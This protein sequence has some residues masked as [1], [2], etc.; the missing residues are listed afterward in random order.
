MIYLDKNYPPV[1]IKVTLEAIR[2]LTAS[3][4]SKIRIIALVPHIAENGSSSDTFPFSTSF[5]T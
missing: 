4:S 2:E 5:L 3:I 1:E